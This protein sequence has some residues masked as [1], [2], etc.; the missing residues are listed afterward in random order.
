MV[1][2][3]RMTQGNDEHEDHRELLKRFDENSRP[4]QTYWFWRDKPLAEREAAAAV[5]TGAGLHIEALRSREIGDDPPD[6]EALVNGMRCGI[7]VTELVHRPTLERSIQ[8]IRAREQG[9][10]PDAPEADFAW[11]RGDLL[12]ALQGL[13]NRK[14]KAKPKGG[15]YGRYILVIVTDEFFLDRSTIEGFLD[16]ATFEA[17]LITDVLLGLSYHPSTELGG[18]SCPVFRLCCDPRNKSLL[19]NL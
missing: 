10:E 13:I 18:G 7:E 19:Q 2:W 9:R 8:A 5:L 15:P 14:D 17:D 3:I 6:C 11:E 1:Q 12:E 4:W 16:G